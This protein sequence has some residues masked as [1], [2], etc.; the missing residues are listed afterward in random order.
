LLIAREAR[1]IS[2]EGEE[3]RPRK[4]AR[5]LMDVMAGGGGGI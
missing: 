3:G 1:E 4:E 2:M 5:E